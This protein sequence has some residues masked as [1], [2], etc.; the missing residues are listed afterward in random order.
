MLHIH[1]L[2]ARLVLLW[3]FVKLLGQFFVVVCCVWLGSASL[4]KLAQL[5]CGKHCLLLLWNSVSDQGW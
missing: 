3:T 5:I 2:K 1:L 4:F